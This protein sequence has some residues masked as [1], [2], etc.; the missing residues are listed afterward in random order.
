MD[1]TVKKTILDNDAM[2]KGLKRLIDSALYSLIPLALTLMIVAVLS[3]SLAVISMSIDYGLSL[4][5]HLFAHQSIRAIMKSNV[6]KFPYGTGK[7]ENFSA[8]LYGT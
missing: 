7:L 5:V 8:F 3:N 6:I 4:V 2:L 1:K